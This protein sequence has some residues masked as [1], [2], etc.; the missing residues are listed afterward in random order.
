MMGWLYVAVW[1]ALAAYLIYVTVRRYRT[2]LMFILS[3]FMVFLGVW[4]LANMLTAVDLKSGAFGWIYRGVA[5]VVLV[6]C[7]I[8]CFILRHR[9]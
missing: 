3:G 4:E 9:D 8:W 7:L 5:A 1:F 6:M 2:P